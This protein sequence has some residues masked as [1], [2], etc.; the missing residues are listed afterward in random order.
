MRRAEGLTRPRPVRDRPQFEFE[1]DGDVIAVTHL[2]IFG[3][4]HTERVPRTLDRACLAAR[5][6]IGLH[7]SHATACD[8]A[9]E[10]RRRIGAPK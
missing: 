2:T 4:T 8:V 10:V 1:L 6:S 5:L 9:D 3:A 7:L